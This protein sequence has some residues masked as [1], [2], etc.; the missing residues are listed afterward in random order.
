[1]P[2]GRTNRRAFIA[3]LG[4]TVRVARVSASAAARAPDPHRISAA[5]LSFES[6]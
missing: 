2:V 3:A 6:L 5:W 4:G 1:M